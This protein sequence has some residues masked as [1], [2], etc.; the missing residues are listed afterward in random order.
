MNT[1]NNFV[2]YNTTF[3]LFRLSPFFTGSPIPPN[4]KMLANYAQNFRDVLSGEALRGIKM[5]IDNESALLSRAG[6]LQNVNWVIL[7]G[8]DLIGIQTDENSL[9]EIEIE[10]RGMLVTVSYENTKY[11]AIFLKDKDISNYNIDFTK[12]GFH[13]FP[14]LLLKMPVKLQKSFTD[15]LASTFDTRISSLFIGEECLKDCF[16]KYISDVCLYQLSNDENMEMNI[17]IENIIKDTVLRLGFDLPNGST[18][19]KT[20]DIQVP[21]K[22]LSN[23]IRMSKTASQVQFFE[24]IGDYLRAHLALDIQNSKVRITRI[25]CAAF[26]LDAEGKFKL[27]QPSSIDEIN[28]QQRANRILISALIKASTGN[29]IP[30]LNNEL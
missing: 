28:A 21:S 6:S 20:I 7:Y 2:L 3:S 30:E 19:L 1:S 9:S 8:K 24:V 10:E 27:T 11:R 18:L 17:K 5:G 14:L 23:M 22:D 29:F 4:D 16:E 15:Y 13:H 26:I 25:S 12:N